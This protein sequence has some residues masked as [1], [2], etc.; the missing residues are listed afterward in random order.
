VTCPVRLTSGSHC[1]KHSHNYEP[2]RK[3]KTC[4][5]ANNVVQFKMPGQKRWISYVKR[6]VFDC[7][8][9]ALFFCLCNDYAEPF[10]PRND[11]C[12][13]KYM[14]FKGHNNQEKQIL[15]FFCFYAPVAAVFTYFKVCV[16]M[17][18][19]LDGVRR[20]NLIP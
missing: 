19:S 12:N 5:E 4:F 9:L 18:E 14:F 13:I 15:I 1:H 6:V 16:P 17:L 10:L 7:L 3:D 20:K 11:I 2:R 8:F